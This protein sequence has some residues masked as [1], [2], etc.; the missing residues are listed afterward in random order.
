MSLGGFDILVG[1]VNGLLKGFQLSETAGSIVRNVNSVQDEDRVE[2]TCLAGKSDGT[3][4][5]GGAD[6]SVRTFTKQD[7]APD[8]LLTA[9]IEEGHKLRGLLAFE[10]KVIAASTSGVV[11]L[12]DD[13]VSLE[14]DEAAEAVGT[15]DVI[16]QS[17]YQ[18]GKL[19]KG[20][21]VAGSPEESEHLGHLRQGRDLSCLVAAPKQRH[22]V[23]TAGKE[24]D[25]QLWDVN[26]AF[27][28]AGADDGCVFRAKNVS[29]DKLELRVPVWVSGVAF[30]DGDDA[31]KISVVSKHGHVRH[32]DTRSKQRRPVL[33][34]EWPDEA[35][36][37]CA[38]LG[39]DKLVV[40]AG[41]G[42]LAMFDWR[43]PPSKSTGLMVQ[44][45]KGCVGS[46]RSLAVT[47]TQ[48]HFVSV[49]LDRYLR[50]YQAD[51]AKPVH[52]VYMKSKLNCMMVSPEFDPSQAIRE[53][54]RAA[55]AK[56]AKKDKPAAVID[57]KAGEGDAKENEAKEDG[58]DKFWTKMKI[59]REKPKKRKNPAQGGE[60]SKR[61]NR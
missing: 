26:R 27:D 8:R 38:A 19:K 15:L 18:S 53:L 55:A 16:K 11:S 2:I 39:P 22:L 45:Y 7:H 60:V 54:A 59:I 20:A 47:A 1:S 17:L 32:Y 41:T 5:V 36:T 13:A 3:V 10:D 37:S 25:L 52:K 29:N 28:S 56:A 58:D 44:K 42:K 23:A 6:G 49:G 12:Y 21:F 51:E 46:V 33:S 35:P 4:L 30:Q 9:S 61:I 40:G 48:G 57:K 24:N 50:V 31:S 43:A 34:S 14:D